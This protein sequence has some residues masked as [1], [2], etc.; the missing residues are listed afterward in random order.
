M[1]VSQTALLSIQGLDVEIANEYK[2]LGIHL[3]NELGWLDN[4]SILYKEDQSC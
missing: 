2:D 1:K 3:N 4:T